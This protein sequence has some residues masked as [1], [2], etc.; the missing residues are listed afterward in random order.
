MSTEP[1]HLKHGR[2]SKFRRATGA[3]A[4]LFESLN[5]AAEAA[6]QK[7]DLIEDLDNSY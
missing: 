4:L 1:S 7:D 2:P 3:K 6:T 5:V